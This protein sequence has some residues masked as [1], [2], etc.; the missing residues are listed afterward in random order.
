MVE[1]GAEE[2]DEAPD[3][4][5]GAEHLGDGQHE[6]GRGDAFAQLAVE[7]EADDF[8]DQHADRLA[9]HRRLGLDP[10]DAPAEHAEA[11]DHR[12]VAVGPDQRVGIGDHLAILVGAGPDRLRDML[13]IDLVADAGARGHDLE[14]VE[15]RGAPFEE[16]V[17]LAV[18]GI[19]KLDVALE[20]LRGTELVDHHAMV[21]DK[22]DRDQRIDLLRIAAER[23]HRVAHRGQVDHRRERR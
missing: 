15:R 7:A 9:E 13:Q 14:I 18:A 10:A 17:A 22:V 4:A 3:H 5:L 21:D 6:V 19:F 8:G 11:I 2:L 12:R 1:P 20:R 23:L 16:F